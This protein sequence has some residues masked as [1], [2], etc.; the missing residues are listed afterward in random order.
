[1]SSRN[2]GRIV[3]LD[4]ESIEIISKARKMFANKVPFCHVIPLV[5]PRCP[6]CNEP[7]IQKFASSRLICV[8]CG[9]E[10]EVVEVR[11]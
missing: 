5:W 7:L 8:G 10:F 4:D 11:K 3:R 1:M 6:H 9:K 2:Y